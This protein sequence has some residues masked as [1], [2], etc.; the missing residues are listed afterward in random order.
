MIL[1]AADGMDNDQIA[2]PDWTP[3][4]RL[5]VSGASASSPIDSAGSSKIRLARVSLC[6]LSS[7]LTVEIKALARQLPANLGLPL[8]P[9]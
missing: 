4:A 9:A 6:P 3:A 7:E 1:T 2:M 5:S 8:F